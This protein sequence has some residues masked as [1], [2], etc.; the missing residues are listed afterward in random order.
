MVY[1]RL[2]EKCDR[3][4]TTLPVFRKTEGALPSA[5]VC[6]CLNLKTN[7]KHTSG[8]ARSSASQS[9]SMHKYISDLHEHV[10]ESEFPRIP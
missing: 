7:S 2:G 4:D 1:L 10:Q 9:T 5:E 8:I 6:R 3:D